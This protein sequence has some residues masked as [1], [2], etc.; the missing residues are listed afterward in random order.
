LRSSRVSTRSTNLTY[1]HEKQSSPILEG[2]LRG[3]NLEITSQND[4]KI[5]IEMILFV[6]KYKQLNI[7]LGAGKA[8]A[9]IPIYIKGLS[10]S[11]E[12]G[13]RCKSCANSSL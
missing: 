13:N 9:L 12:K 6:Y 4:C 3:S 1:T 5:V 7:C 11:G 8:L 2:F 10:L